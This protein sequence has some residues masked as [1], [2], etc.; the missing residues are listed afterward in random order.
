MTSFYGKQKSC[1]F[2]QRRRN[3]KSE[4]RKVND[5]SRK[6]FEMKLCQKEKLAYDTQKKLHFSSY[7]FRRV[8]SYDYFDALDVKDEIAVLAI[9]L[10]F[11]LSAISGLKENL[12]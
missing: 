5:L 10:K 6:Y 2:R 4:N 7:S 3:E 8:V 11:Y 9:I 12:Q 1:F